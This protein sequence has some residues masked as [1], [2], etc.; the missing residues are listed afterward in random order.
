MIGVSAF[1]VGEYAAA[2]NDNHDR[3]FTWF[4]THRACIEQTLPCFT[5]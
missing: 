4:Q 3:M 2:F 1:V 5:G